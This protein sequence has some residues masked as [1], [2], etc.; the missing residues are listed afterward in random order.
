MKNETEFAEL[1]GGKRQSLNID[2]VNDVTHGL[3][4]QDSMNIL[5]DEKT[6]AKNMDKMRKYQ[7]EEGLGTLSKGIWYVCVVWYLIG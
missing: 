2:S 6:V 4:Y 1:E 5:E 3:P 7:E